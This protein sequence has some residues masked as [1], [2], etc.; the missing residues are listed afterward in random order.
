VNRDNKCSRR[1]FIT[2]VGMAGAFLSGISTRRAVPQEVTE[3]VKKSLPRPNLILLLTDDQRWD[4]M[5]CMGNSIIRTPNLD[6]LASEGILFTNNFC[7]TSICMSSRAS[8]FTGMYTR[9][10]QINSFAQ[11]LPDNLFSQTYPVLLRKAGYRTGFI[12]KW[13]IGGR[14]PQESFDYFEGFPGQGQYFHKIDGKEV[15]LTRVLTEKA[16]EFL[17]GCS[18][19]QPF[20][21]SVSFKSPHVQDGHPKPFRYDPELEGLYGDIEIPKPKKSDPRYFE[22]LPDFIRESEGRVRWEQRFSTPELYQQSVKGYYR[23]IT[24]V[25]IAL[26]KILELLDEME[27]DDNTVI[28]HTSDNGFYLGE[29]GLAG[30]WLMHEESI[31][32]PLIVR[33][34]RL[35]AK[36]T[37]RKCEQMTLNVDVAPT[38]LDLAG[39]STPSGVQGDSLLP[40][41]KGESPRWREEFFYEHLFAHKRIP[42]NEGVRTKQWKYVR[43]LDS[44][45]LYEEL[46]DLKSDPLEKRN[47]AK[48]KEYRAVL[49]RLRKRWGELRESVV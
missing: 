39:L 38:L 40:L 16:T 43:Y 3:A 31:R 28:L 25:D 29:Y 23:L 24:G 46:Y 10:H 18:K 9:R 15:H 47:V 34:P 7:T 2:R 32:T 11:P 20:C 27:L 37:G 44:D 33:D 14:L 21:L 48:V 4:A 22:A 5:G 36:L 19:D 30:K 42:R 49:A 6:R 8:I 35:P 26:G 17:R 13:G 1:Q 12:G 41:L 45:P